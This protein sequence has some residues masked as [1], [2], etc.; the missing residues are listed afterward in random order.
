MLWRNFKIY[1][2]INE[3]VYQKIDSRNYMVETHKRNEVEIKLENVELLEKK[4]RRMP[5]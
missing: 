2:D 4:K 3:I 1:R 5:R